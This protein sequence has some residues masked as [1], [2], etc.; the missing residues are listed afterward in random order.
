[1]KFYDFSLAPNPK[2]VRMFLA[3]KG[4]TVPSVSINA[5]QGEQFTD[6][7]RK[8]NPFT[9]VPALELD[10]GT[11]IS[12]S[13]AICRYFEET[14][15][16]PPLFGEG[17]VERARVEMWTRR[18]ELHGYLSAADAV[19]NVAPLFEGR[20]VPGVT[21]GVP[22][23]PEL[24][25]RGRAMFARFFRTVEPHLAAN[26]FFAGDRFTIADITGYIAVWFGT[27]AELAIPDDCPNA[28]RWHATV[29]ARPS[30]EA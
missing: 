23:I 5:R 1:M 4:L 25:E 17:A 15:P 2:R 7:Y 28:A 20:G 11:T 14:H 22:Q 13:V 18:A 6:E 8:V 19:R 10:D 3:E 29:A 27:R 21:G 30:A 9:V 26:E 24:A 12:E 16:E